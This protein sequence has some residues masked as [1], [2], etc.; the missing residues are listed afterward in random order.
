MPITCV[1]NYRSIWLFD[2]YIKSDLLIEV[3]RFAKFKGIT[4]IKWNAESKK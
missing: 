1:F 2:N 3:N 4:E